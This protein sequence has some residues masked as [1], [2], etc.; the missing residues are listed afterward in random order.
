MPGV[1]EDA[2]VRFD[3][4]MRGVREGEYEGAL[5]ADDGGAERSEDFA[6]S[7]GIMCGSYVCARCARVYV[8]ND[9][10]WRL[11]TPEFCHDCLEYL[12]TQYATISDPET[13]Q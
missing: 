2:E 10:T 11:C 7:D 13:I 9:P 5:R 3:R 4:Q 12:N 6:M 8:V 1:R